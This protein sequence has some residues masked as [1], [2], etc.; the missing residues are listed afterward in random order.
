MRATASQGEEEVPGYKKNLFISLER[1]QG[2]RRHGGERWG[3]LVVKTSQ[4][5]TSMWGVGVAVEGDH[6]LAPFIESEAGA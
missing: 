6:H 3:A 4:S 1:G 5:F 2:P